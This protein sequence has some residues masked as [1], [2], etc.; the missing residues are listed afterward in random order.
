MKLKKIVSQCKTSGMVMLYTRRDG[1]QLLSDGCGIWPIDG[2][3]KLT[4][5]ALK[6]IFEMT[7]KKWKDSIYYREF[8][9][10]ENPELPEQDAFAGL[11]E[12]ML[13]DEWDADEEIQVERTDVTV[14]YQ[15]T[16]FRCYRADDGRSVYVSDRRFDPLPED[17]QFTMIRQTEAVG[18]PG[19]RALA[20]YDGVLMCGLILCAPAST[21]AEINAALGN[22]ITGRFEW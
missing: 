3:L 18:A 21:A 17:I 12:R 8:D 16:V 10:S 4:E 15:N 2:G 7:D 1:M 20:A 9:Y 14:M 13:E 5:D 11:A 19:L 6:I 22:M